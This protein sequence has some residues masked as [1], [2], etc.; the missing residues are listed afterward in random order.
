[1]PLKDG[2][3]KMADWAKDAGS[4]A[5][6]IFSNIEVLEKLPPSWAAAMQKEVMD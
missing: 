3:Q 1:M 6:G 5:S 2:L 4:R